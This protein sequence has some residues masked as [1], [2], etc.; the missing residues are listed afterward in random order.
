MGLISRVSSRTYREM[1]RISQTRAFFKKTKNEVPKI[2]LFTTKYN[3]VFH[4][5]L[6]NMYTYREASV[7]N[8]F[9]KHPDQESSIKKIKTNAIR[10]KFRDEYTDRP[11]TIIINKKIFLQPEFL[12]WINKQGLDEKKIRL[13]EEYLEGKNDPKAKYAFS[14]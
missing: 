1:L 3:S 10:N 6:T 12:K 14:I 7:E 2:D 11:A 9:E 13:E 5:Y 4:K 8:L